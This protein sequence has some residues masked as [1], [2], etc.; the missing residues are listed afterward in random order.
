MNN[1]RALSGHLAALLTVT[2]W[3][4]TYVSTKI[5][6]HDFTPVEILLARFIIGALALMLIYPKSLG[7]KKSEE[8]YYVF[9]GLTGGCL[10]FLTENIALTM[11]TAVNVGIILVVTPMLTAV[12]TRLFYRDEN[13]LTP[14]FFL[15]FCAALAGILILSLHGSSV[16]INPLGDLMAVGAG[17]VWAFYSVVCK[18]ISTFGHNTIAVTRRSFLY[19]IIFIAIAASFMD[20]S[21]DMTRFLKPENYGNLLFLGLAAS[22]M[23]FA[24]WNFAV[25]IIG[26]VTSI[27]YLYASP[28]LTVLFAWLILGEELTALGLV[29]C[30]L[31]MIGLVL[32]QN[33]KLP[34]PSRK[35]HG[36]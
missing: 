23:C 34:L 24:T 1:T 36:A 2:V 15:G 12:V 3:S 14:R 30:V 17:L 32:S 20:T 31:I 28:V 9:A 5:L 18:K 27:I 29:G 6:L 11:T 13:H 7:F 19:G 22:A 10:Y 4:V 35:A 25:K 8:I 21:S 16:S 33:I 26:P